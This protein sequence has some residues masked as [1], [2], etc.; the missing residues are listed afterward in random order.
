MCVFSKPCCF[1]GSDSGGHLVGEKERVPLALFLKNVFILFIYFW[2]RCVFIAVH[3]LSLVAVSRGYSSL[4]CAGFSLRWLL[5]LRSM[6]SRHTGFS[7]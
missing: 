7:S 5:L 4:W 2:L 3:S 1:L 6:G